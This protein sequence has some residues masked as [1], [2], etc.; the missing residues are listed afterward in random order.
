MRSAWRIAVLTLVAIQALGWLAPDSADAGQ[1]EIMDFGYAPDDFSVAVGDHVTWLNTG[2]QVHS[3]VADADSPERFSSARI[4]PGGRFMHTFK[5]PGTVLYHCEFHRSMKGVVRVGQRPATDPKP[6]PAPSRNDAEA[7]TTTAT[8]AHRPSTTGLTTTEA[9]ATTR[10]PTATTQPAPRPSS[11][12]VVAQPGLPAVP[13]STTA[14]P[15]PVSPSSPSWAQTTGPPL[16]DRT[17]PEPNDG[18]AT[19]TTAATGSDAAAEVT[20]GKPS[21]QPWRGWADLPMAAL[22]AA[23]IAGGAGWLVKIRLDQR[24]DQRS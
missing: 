12:L 15:M 23:L 20:S 7:S 4:E 2:G 5:T 22:G 19:T 11:P 1:T 10:L 21:S 9:P 24:F 14:V 8:N 6:A 16:D 3:V 13:P 18:S 17:P